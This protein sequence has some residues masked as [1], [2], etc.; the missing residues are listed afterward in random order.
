V[1]A[2]EKY[3]PGNNRS[4]VL[5]TDRNTVICDSYNANPE[6]MRKAIDAFLEAPGGDKLMV[7]GDMLELGTN[8]HEEHS[9]ILRILNNQGFTNVFLVGHQFEAIAKEF[10]YKSFSGVENLKEYLKQNQVTG[11]QI[12]VK[13]SRGIML[14]KIYDLL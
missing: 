14:E 1:D 3:L 6:S 5:K 13:G 8:S 4:Q 9:R 10:G 7:L 12:L 11:K 2:I